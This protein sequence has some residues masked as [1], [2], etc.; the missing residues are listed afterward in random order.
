MARAGTGI[1]HL[2]V[3][4]VQKLIPR[5]KEFECPLITPVLVKAFSQALPVNVTVVVYLES[6]II[7]MQRHQ[8]SACPISK[9]RKR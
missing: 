4:T 8:Q 7:C 1:M 9:A 6:A 5:I 3:L 2:K